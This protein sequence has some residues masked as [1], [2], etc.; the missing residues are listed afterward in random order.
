MLRR[1]ISFILL[2]CSCYLNSVAVEL[3]VPPAPSRIHSVRLAYLRVGHSG[4]SSTA[5]Y[6]LC[7]AL[8]PFFQNFIF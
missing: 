1:V 8:Y 2:T 4:P 5:M 3:S 7:I 6:L